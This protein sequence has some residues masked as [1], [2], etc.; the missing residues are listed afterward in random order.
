MERDEWEQVSYVMVLAIRSGIDAKVYF[1]AS[2]PKA[3]KQ[4]IFRQIL[5]TGRSNLIEEVV[6][7]LK[8]QPGGVGGIAISDALLATSD[9]STAFDI[10]TRTVSHLGSAQRNSMFKSLEEAAST[11]I[12]RAQVAN[13]RN[14][15]H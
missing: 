15:Y 4:V 13:L 1:D 3:L 6:N 7:W 9:F 2:I 12:Q 14:R 10:A 8:V 11:Q 5:S